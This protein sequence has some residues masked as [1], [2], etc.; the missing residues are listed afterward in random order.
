MRCTQHP[1]ETGPVR[2]LLPL[3]LLLSAGC[4]GSTGTDAKAPA[5]PTAASTGSPGLS[6]GAA[7]PSAGPAAAA[8]A[9]RNL[10]LVTVD[11]LRTDRLGCYGGRS[12][13]TPAYDRLAREGTLFE[14][15]VATNPLTLPAHVS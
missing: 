13:A 12:P 3:L 10:L 2:F 4:G 6:A 9:I 15:A 5:P 8:G 1:G 14:N 11:T 7:T